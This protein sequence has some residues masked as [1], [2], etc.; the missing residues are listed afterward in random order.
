VK[1]RP[2]AIDIGYVRFDS[3]IRHFINIAEAGIG[4]EVVDRMNRA[5]KHLGGRVSV[6]LATFGGLSS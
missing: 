2:R 5:P 3:Q 6:L 4:A 1:G